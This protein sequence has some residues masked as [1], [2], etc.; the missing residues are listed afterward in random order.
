MSAL[1][2]KIVISPLQSKV[3]HKDKDEYDFNQID[4]VQSAL[5]WLIIRELG[6]RFW[7]RENE[8]TQTALSKHHSVDVRVKED[9]CN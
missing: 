6:D 5:L 4:S 3:H 7:Y 8:V 9:A 1:L 2:V